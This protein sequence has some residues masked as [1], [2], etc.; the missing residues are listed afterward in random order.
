MQKFKD[1]AYQRP[2]KEEL[3]REFTD[4]IQQFSSAGSFEQAHEAFLRWHSFVDRMIS[5]YV[6]A[7][8]RNTVNMKDE[9]YNN[10]IEFFNET[11]PQLTPLQK[12]WGLMQRKYWAAVP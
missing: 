5:M 2:D 4:C 7:Y 8:I 10:E 6:I 12:Q 11:L 1:L 3:V 9:F